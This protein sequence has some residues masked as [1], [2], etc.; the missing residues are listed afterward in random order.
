MLFLLVIS[1][2]DPG[3]EAAA[4]ARVIILVI[5]D[6]IGKSESEV[7]ADSSTGDLLSTSAC[8]VATFSSSSSTF[9]FVTSFVSL[10][11]LGRVEYMVN[12]SE[13]SGSQPLCLKEVK[14]KTKADEQ[15]KEVMSRGETPNKDSDE[16]HNIEAGVGFHSNF[17]F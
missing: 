10:M 4:G 16:K 17:S 8:L 15:S 13:I 6:G 11:L 7:I 3:V 1:R 12:G 14:R 9:I 2:F 5:L